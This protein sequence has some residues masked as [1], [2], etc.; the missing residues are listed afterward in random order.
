MKISKISSKI[1]DFDGN[2][3]SKTLGLILKKEPILPYNK[4]NH[5]IIIL[6]AIN[7]LTSYFSKQPNP[8]LTRGDRRPS[9][10]LIESIICEITNEIK[11]LEIKESIYRCGDFNSHFKEFS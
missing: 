9:T 4:R 8:K 6:S 1:I 7:A 10:L 2:L 11:D 5:A 3:I